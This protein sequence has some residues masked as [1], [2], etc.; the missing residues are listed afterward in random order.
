[1]KKIIIIYILAIICTSCDDFL[2]A[3]P[4]KDIVTP[5]TEQALRA[6]LDNAESLNRLPS[7]SVLCS[8]EFITNDAGLRVYSSQWLRELYIWNPSP[9]G[10][11]EFIADWSSPYQTIF[12]ANVIL[13]ELPKIQGLSTEAFNDLKGSALF[14]RALSYYGL[15]QIFLPTYSELQSSDAKLVLRTSPNIN[16]PINYVNGV[17][18]YNQIFSDLE[19]AFELLPEVSQYPTRP[20]KNAVNALLARIYLSMEDYDNAL[21][22]ANRTLSEDHM[23]MDY[24]EIPVRILP[25]QNFNSEVILYAE[26]INYTFTAVLTSQVEPSLLAS[27]ATNDLRSK[28]FF[29]LRP[30][31]FTNF[32]GNYTQIFRHFGGLAYNE[33]Y[34]IAAEAEARVGSVNEGLN[35]LNQLLIN[36]YESGWEPYQINNREEL[37]NLVLA[38]RRKELA[39]R[40]TRWSDLRRLNKDPRFQ[41]TI[42]RIVEGEEY[43][44][45][46]NS[47]KY[48]IPIP[49]REL[50]FDAN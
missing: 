4:T 46:P 25:F 34:L 11:D 1:M 14:L 40:G 18:I 8:D 20:V 3:K 29:T 12:T 32:T 23:L 45:E 22:Y 6:L 33:V 24:N 47:P 15:S 36:R 5:N 26:L 10:P 44:L 21:T 37:L 16:Q 48:V 30:N 50:A 31:G 2:D 39:F 41:K 42:T 19:E 35:Y 27:Y 9:F 49:P 43:R 17:E 28:L 13:E 7:I 38:E